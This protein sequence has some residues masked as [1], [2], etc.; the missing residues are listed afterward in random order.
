M[1]R[2]YML[3][4]TEQPTL[5]IVRHFNKELRSNYWLNRCCVLISGHGCHV[6][7]QKSKELIHFI[8]SDQ[9][10]LRDKLISLG[11]VLHYSSPGEARFKVFSPEKRTHLMKKKEKLIKRI[12]VSWVY[13]FDHTEWQRW[14]A[15]RSYCRSIKQ[16]FL[17]SWA[18]TS[19]QHQLWCAVTA[20]SAA[21]TLSTSAVQVATGMLRLSATKHN[22]LQKHYRP[23]LKGNLK[24]KTRW[25]KK[26]SECI[27]RGSQPFPG[28]TL[29]IIKAE[30]SARPK[31]R[32]MHLCRWKLCIAFKS[33]WY[34]YPYH[35]FIVTQPAMKYLH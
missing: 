27:Q 6:N 14:A 10:L 3:A 29:A 19:A 23:S 24:H 30:L 17:Q 20:A 2:W 16:C 8:F 7:Q 25:R 32:S 33:N 34:L 9:H 11:D 15:G 22:T 26:K 28:Y 21:V 1:Y 13:L 31:K 12:S 4:V 18:V 5:S 35:I